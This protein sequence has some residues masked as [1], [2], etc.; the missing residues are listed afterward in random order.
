LPAACPE[1]EIVLYADDAKAYKVIK[2]RQ[3]RA[4]LQSSLNALCT[5]AKRWLLTLSLDKCLYLQ[6]GYNDAS[7]FYVLDGHVLRPSGVVRDLGITIQSNLKPGMHC[8]EIA[9]KA[10]IRANLI[11]KSFLSHDPHNLARAF[12]VYVR[13]LLEYSTPVWSP[14]GKGDIEIIENVQRTFTRKVF[15]LCH[16]PQTNYEGRLLHLGLQRLELRRIHNDLIFLFKIMH[17]T[18]HSKLR[19]V[20]HF[21]NTVNTRGHRHKL[22]ITRTHKQVLSTF[23]VCRVSPIWNFLPDACFNVNQLDYFKRKLKEIDFSRFLK[24][25]S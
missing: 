9:H 23:F 4:L 21:A 12:S 22:F 6:L 7:L 11:L 25:R 10:N 16:L 14:C 19:H 18:V 3:D 5:W 8:T 15:H 13:P 2:N 20:L 1:C 17:G 24:G